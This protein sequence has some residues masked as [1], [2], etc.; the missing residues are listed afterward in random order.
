[1]FTNLSSFM[2]KIILLTIFF[3]SQ[4]CI[5]SQ[6]T[7]YNSNSIGIYTIPDGARFD[8]A[9]DRSFGKFYVFENSNKDIS[10]HIIKS[11]FD[12]TSKKDFRKY[13]YNIITSM[14]NIK[15]YLE[16]KRSSSKILKFAEQK[17]S[18]FMEFG[19]EKKMKSPEKIYMFITKSQEKLFQIMIEAKTGK[20]KP[21][22]IA[23]KF[24]ENINISTLSN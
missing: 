3:H 8:Y 12:Y 24:L 14:Y 5:Y 1:M 11:P 23:L 13:V 19:K 22:K 10:I 21:P 15:F 20:K 6:N 17:K 16:N 9:E 2:L 4:Y 7:Y 18:Y